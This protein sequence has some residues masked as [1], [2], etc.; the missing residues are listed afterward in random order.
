MASIMRFPVLLSQPEVV[1]LS[2]GQRPCSGWSRILRAL[3]E[4]EPV[5]SGATGPQNEWY[6][7]IPGEVL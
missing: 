1:K 3:V 7:R 6:L 5:S 2:K 4:G